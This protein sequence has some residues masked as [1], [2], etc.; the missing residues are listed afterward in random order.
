[1]KYIVKKLVTEYFW[2]V[3]VAKLLSK[4]EFNIKKNKQE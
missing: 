1:M 3:S 4:M 2:H